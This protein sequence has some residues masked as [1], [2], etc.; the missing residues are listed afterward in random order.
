MQP[1][2]FTAY[3]KPTI[4]GGTDIQRLKKIDNAGSK[5][6][7][8]WEISG[9]PEHQTPVC[10]GPDDGLT[11]TQLIEKYGASLLGEKNFRHYGTHFPLLFKY[12]SAEDDLS[13]QVHPDDEAAAKLGHPFGKTEM[14]YILRAR[15]DAKIIA[16]FRPGTTPD[17]NRAS[18]TDGTV[19]H[20]VMQHEAHSGDCFFIPARRIHGLGAGNFVVEIQQASDDTYRIYDYDR[21]DDDGNLRELHID[22]ARDVIRF[23]DTDAAPRNYQRL[24]NTPAMLIDVPQF[25]TRLL[26]ADVP[27]SLDY[28]HTDSFV[29]IMAF[30]GH[31]DVTDS[32]GNL[33]SLKAGQTVLI[34]A[35]TRGLDLRPHTKFS[36]I[37]ALIK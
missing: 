35:T 31:A 34:P 20:H 8:S 9:L 12:L 36:C 7:E 24:K 33:F 30:E 37:E 1:F 19:M 5:I 23:D 11:P 29:V 22:A 25:Q 4:W 32:E 13:L 16:G 17:D 18:L 27:L 26:R 2:F 6:G 21:R 14:W 15:R 3:L 28:S 10:G